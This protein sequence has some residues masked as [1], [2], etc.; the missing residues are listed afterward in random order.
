[1]H[2][3]GREGVDKVLVRIKSVC[4]CVCQTDKLDQDSQKIKQLHRGTF[5]FKKGSQLV[6]NQFVM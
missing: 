5:A 1:M 4:V 6:S 2:V 3:G